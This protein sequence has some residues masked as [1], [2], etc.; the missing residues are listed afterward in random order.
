M[1]KEE[2]LAWDKWANEHVLT[3]ATFGWKDRTGETEITLSDCT[4]NQALARAKD[5]GYQEPKWYKPW[6][7]MNWVVTVG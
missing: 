2:Q 7:W 3:R 5:W 4:Y 1:T 6:T